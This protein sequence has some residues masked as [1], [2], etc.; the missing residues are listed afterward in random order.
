VRGQRDAHQIPSRAPA[1]VR[2]WDE[3]QRDE[4]RCRPAT[5]QRGLYERTLRL[6]TL[7][8]P[9]TVGHR[10]PG[11]TR[12]RSSPGRAWFRPTRPTLGA[13]SRPIP[14]SSTKR[15]HARTSSSSPAPSSGAGA[16]PR[17]TRSMRSSSSPTRG[18][19]SGCERRCGRRS[20]IWCGS[21]SH[22]RSGS[23]CLKR[24]PRSKPRVPASRS[25]MGSKRIRPFR[26]RV[27]RSPT[28]PPAAGS[29]L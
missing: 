20:R 16:S 9:G 19:G 22:S 13:W 3:L 7:D 8:L 14:A 12:T 27:R 17:S 15:S 18:C 29:G 28:A 6:R 26:R 11:A 1:P 21:R 25:R 10:M 5:I 2:Q 4:A 24:R 23:P